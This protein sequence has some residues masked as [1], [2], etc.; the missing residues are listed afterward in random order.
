MVRIHPDPPPPKGASQEQSKVAKSEGAV[1]QLGEHLLCKQG[2]VGSIPIS[3][4]NRDLTSGIRDQRSQ[5][6]ARQGLLLAF[7][8]TFGQ[9]CLELF[10]NNMEEVKRL[11]RESRL[12][13]ERWS[14]ERARL[15]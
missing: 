4:T 9:R 10:F 14:E 13:R 2:V 7:S 11:A 8:R 12:L 6:Q 1:A 5:K 15:G 3:S